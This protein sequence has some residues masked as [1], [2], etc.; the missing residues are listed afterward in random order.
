MNLSKLRETR[1]RQV[2]GGKHKGATSSA[3]ICYLLNIKNSLGEK[4]GEMRGT[5]G[6]YVIAL[7]LVTALASR[8]VWVFA[9]GSPPSD[10]SAEPDSDPAA[11][12][13][14]STTANS[15]STV[16]TV[17]PSGIKITGTTINASSVG[18]MIGVVVNTVTITD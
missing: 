6:K 18:N 5:K 15:S 7:V 1:I 14:T 13:A 3:E 11:T 17:S 9:A 16:V 8:P 2:I 10:D 4:K 12:T